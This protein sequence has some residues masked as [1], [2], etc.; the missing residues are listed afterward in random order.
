MP[1]KRKAKRSNISYY[2]RITDA[3]SNQLIGHLSDITKNG[4]K[5]DS[6]KELPVPKEYRLRIYTNSEISNKDYIE[7]IASTRWCKPDS[8]DPGLFDIGFEIIKIDSHDSE[9]IQR[10]IDKYT[11]KQI[12][13]NF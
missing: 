8:M 7:F 3:T 2:L 6:R 10:M 9:T 5:I 11:T 4:L 13:L 12:S 1:E